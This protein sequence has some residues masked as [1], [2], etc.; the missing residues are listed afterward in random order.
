MLLSYSLK[1]S[2]NIIDEFQKSDRGGVVR[3][4]TGMTKEYR[5]NDKFRIF[6]IFSRGTSLPPPHAEAGATS[7]S[8]FG[9]K[10]L[11]LVDH[12]QRNLAFGNEIRAAP[13]SRG[14]SPR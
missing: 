8:G 12:A 6:G 1:N 10:G 14:A 9:F 3:I 5:G 13:S 7:D 2:K 4:E 11:L